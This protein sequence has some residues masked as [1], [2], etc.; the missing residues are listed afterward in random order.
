MSF[1][2]FLGK[3][4][5]NVPYNFHFQQFGSKSSLVKSSYESK[6]ARLSLTSTTHIF[7]T[8]VWTLYRWWDVLHSLQYFANSIFMNFIGNVLGLYTFFITKYK[9]LCGAKNHVWLFVGVFL[10][11]PYPFI[12]IYGSLWLLKLCSLTFKYVFNQSFPNAFFIVIKSK[13]FFCYFQMN[14]LSSILVIQMCQSLISCV[15]TPSLN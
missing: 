3:Y 11:H 9:F 7:W 1:L 13:Y 14:E 12:K 8:F 5:L 15:K 4:S 10:I 6:K 2:L